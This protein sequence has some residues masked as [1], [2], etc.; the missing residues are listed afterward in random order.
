VAVDLSELRAEALQPHELEEAVAGLEDPTGS[1][2]LVAAE[3]QV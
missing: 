1:L 2:A 3:Y